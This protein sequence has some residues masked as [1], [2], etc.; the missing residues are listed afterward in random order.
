MLHL[1]SHSQPRQP[2]CVAVRAP[3]DSAGLPGEV[4]RNPHSHYGLVKQMGLGN[5]LRLIPWVV[6]GTE[7]ARGKTQ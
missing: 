1:P 2:S 6:W 4:G 3:L 7:A 5:L